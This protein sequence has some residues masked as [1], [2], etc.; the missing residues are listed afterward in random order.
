MGRAL[1]R[2]PP[3]ARFL[4]LRSGVLVL[5]HLLQASLAPVD[6]SGHHCG[7]G[8]HGFGVQLFT[9]DDAS[10]VVR[11]EDVRRKEVFGSL[12]ARLASALDSCQSVSIGTDL[13]LGPSGGLHL[14]PSITH[15]TFFG[16]NCPAALWELRSDPLLALQPADI[17][18]IR[19]GLDGIYF[20]DVRH[21]ILRDVDFTARITGSVELEVLIEWLGARRRSGLGIRELCIEKC[22]FPPTRGKE[23]G[24]DWEALLTPAAA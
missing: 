21:V 19:P 15:L 16:R 12:C 1:A 6:P 11:S 17:S 22:V 14:L 7:H 5:H 3:L 9:T 23:E 18:N 13:G 24:K 8:R 2:L 10:F 4:A 20:P